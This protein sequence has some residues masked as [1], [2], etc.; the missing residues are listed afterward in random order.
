MPTINIRKANREDLPVILKL[1][2][3][4]DNEN[5][6]RLDLTTAEEIF[7]RMQTYPSYAIYLA[8]REGEIIGTF[9]L[10]IMDN[11]AHFGAS[12]GI[13]ENVVV[14]QQFQGQGIGKI[15]M[16]Y[17]MQRCAEAGCYKL[18]LSSSVKREQAHHFYESLGFERYGYSFQIKLG[19]N[20]EDSRN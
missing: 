10:L 4:F 3:V 15:M 2:R 19:K 1:Y 14:P 20:L 9:A 12:E 13:V 6:P 11:L 16:E 7:A 18:V 17:A 5:D 8:E